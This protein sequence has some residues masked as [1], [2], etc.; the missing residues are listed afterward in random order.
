[1]HQKGRQHSLTVGRDVLRLE[2]R[3]NILLCEMN[4]LRHL[5][6]KARINGWRC[7]VAGAPVRDDKSREV[8]PCLEDVLERQRLLAGPVAVDPATARRNE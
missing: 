2:C 6:V 7:G 4:V 1:M 5:E 3:H 8:V